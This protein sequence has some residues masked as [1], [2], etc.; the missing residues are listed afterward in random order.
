M[1]YPGRHEGALIPIGDAFNHASR[2]EGLE[3]SFEQFDAPPTDFVYT[4]ERN[5]D[6]G[7]EITDS[8]G[9]KPVMTLF[10]DY[11]FVEDFR[12]NADGKFFADVAGHELRLLSAGFLKLAERAGA[13]VAIEGYEGLGQARVFL[14]D[15]ASRARVQVPVEGRPAHRDDAVQQAFA[16]LL[17]KALDDA[18]REWMPLEIC[19]QALN[20]DEGGPG[21]GNATM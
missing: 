19:L 14:K 13:L 4:A 11:G 5:I 1:S 9:P 8:Y 15:L 10:T 3:Y 12:D 2:N 6:A 7:E 16:G 21:P 17:T 20:I 18:T